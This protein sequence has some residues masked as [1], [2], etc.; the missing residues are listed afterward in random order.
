MNGEV[1][2]MTR[3]RLSLRKKRK[4]S[5]SKRKQTSNMAGWL[6]QRHP[7]AARFFFF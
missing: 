3:Y 1:L 5:R 6:G 4:A 7:W 2:M